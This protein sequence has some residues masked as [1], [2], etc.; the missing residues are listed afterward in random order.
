MT[1]FPAK[2]AAIKPTP[3]QI[4][5]LS[6]NILVGQNQNDKLPCVTSK[7]SVDGSVTWIWPGLAEKYRNLMMKLIAAFFLAAFN[8]SAQT[9]DLTMATAAVARD[10]TS[11][12]AQGVLRPEQIRAECLQ[13]RRI[14]CGR[15]LKV[16]PG[17]L[18]VDSGYTDLLRPPLNASWLV[19]GNVVASRPANLVESREARSVCVGVVFVTDVP[20]AHGTGAK[21]RPYD[22]VVLLGY[23][24]GQSTY[25]SVG[26]IHKTVRRFSANLFQAVKLNL[27]AA[28][29]SAQPPL[30]K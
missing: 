29:S 16:L 11:Q 27:V 28:E 6:S 13:G 9:N 5:A 23:P 15:I 25:V 4:K 14:I 20:K 1:H 22:Y 18:V 26:T 24:A 2:L 21:P 19:P 30:P 12:S 10:E 3:F 17:G 7:L 8:L